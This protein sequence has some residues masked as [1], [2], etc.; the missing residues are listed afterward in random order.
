M[1]QLTR[2]A[3]AISTTIDPHSIR[4]SLV[5]AMVSIALLSGLVNV[6]F[7]TGS[8]F[9]L[10]VYDRV[11]PSRSI[12]TLV[13]LGIIALALYL[14][15][16]FFDIMRGR[17]LVRTASAVDRALGRKAYDRV[18]A[19]PL[20]GQIR[21]DGLQLLRDVDQI[22]AYLASPSPAAL[23][24]LPWVPLYLAVCFAFHVW[25]GAAVL[26]GSILLIAVTL[27]TEVLTRSPSRAA[28][29][30][31][32]ER[33]G[34]AAAAVRNAEVLRAMGMASHAGNKWESASEKHLLGQRRI[35]DIAGGMSSLTKVVR[36]ALQS[37][38]LGLGALLVIQ[39]QATGGIMIAS[40]V[41]V[42]RALAPVE[43]AIGNW[44]P[45]VAARQS[46]KR[47]R[48]A[49]EQA[50][51]R[52]KAKLPA[53]CRTLVVEAISIS[54]PGENRLIAHNV[55]FTL[56][57]GQGLAIIGPSGSGKSTLARALAGVWQ[58]IQGKVK[59][60]GASLDQW[61]LEWLGRHVGYVPQDVE[62]FAG[63]VAENI[64]RFAPD[65]VF[66]DIVEAAQQAG[67]HELICSL[68]EGYET[69]V[70][71]GGNALSGGQRQR[72]A[73]ARALYGKPFL[74]V[75][76]EPNSNLDAEGE[77]AL[78]N[79]LAGARRR[80]AVVVIVA[81]RPSILAGAD[82]VLVMTDGRARAYGPTEAVLQHLKMPVAAR[83]SPSQGRQVE[84]A[85]HT[86]LG[87][88]RS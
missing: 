21:G 28:T 34:L 49:L 45:F 30:A 37:L 88:V 20:V 5:I 60:D 1:L 29:E 73:L 82:Q 12:P 22:R 78:M 23:F 48:A 79:A 87:V 71:D 84:D 83:S 76:D 35:A 53:P 26:V 47:L 24:D 3:G 9:M 86:K 52:P 66:D 69:R 4:R 65:A 51:Q 64:A 33:S 54:A 67:V 19:A 14:F 46:W 15:Q 11:L 70:G 36:F 38:V 6:L 72:I 77:A 27:L 25:I 18:V 57:A 41:L 39:G 32:M 55:S 68:P 44:K 58:P 62:L 40:S 8:L 59:L 17:L 2:P 63:S 74:L 85:A 42:G 50:Q 43:L 75:L 56:R 13:G 61:P 80:G 10:E 81:H 31:A 16:G 7:L